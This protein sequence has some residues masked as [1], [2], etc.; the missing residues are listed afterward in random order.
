[1]AEDEW[2]IW[3]KLWHNGTLHH[4]PIIVKKGLK[5]Q[6]IYYVCVIIIRVFRR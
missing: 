1:M 3:D 6:Y 4:L 5:V 2:L